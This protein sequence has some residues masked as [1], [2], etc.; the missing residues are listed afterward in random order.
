MMKKAIALLLLT[1]AMLP[2][3]PVANAMEETV[4]ITFWHPHGNAHQEITLGYVED[5]NQSIGKEKGIVV[6]VVAIPGGY[7]NITALTKEAIANG[8]APDIVALGNNRV[9]S[10]IDE[11]VLVDMMPLAERAGFDVSNVLAPFLSV[12]GNTNGTLHSL[13]YS[14]SIPLLYYN[15][16]MAD[17][18]NLTI[19][20]RIG[21]GF[22]TFCEGLHE[23]DPQ[24]GETTVYGLEMINDF[25]YLQAAHIYQLGSQVIA[26][27]GSGSP[28]L[29]D[30]SLLRV[31]E[32]WRKGVDEGWI[33]PFSLENASAEALTLFYSEKL[34][35]V[36]QSSGALARVLNNAKK[37]GFEVGVLPYPTYGEQGAQ[38]GGSNL[39]M[40]KGNGKEEEAFAFV[41]YLLS[42][43]VVVNNAIET[44][45]IPTTRSAGDSSRMIEFWN[46]NTMFSIAYM[47][48]QN[49]RPQENPYFPFIDDFFKVC[50]DTLNEL[51]QTRTIT[52][53]EAVDQIRSNTQPL[54]N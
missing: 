41:Q 8:T 11:D 5:F 51:I 20:N 42:D 47:Q 54:F 50:Q 10:F 49:S 29:E 4:R 31:L 39:C 28:M 44:G 33:R 26:F 43:E 52:P 46:N 16:T 1:I 48:M 7:D 27:D 53:Q 15:K 22:F 12:Y 45:Y 25:S 34:G 23:K 9:G 19:D 17:A 35:A 32:D 37:N 2:T 36:V 24:T 38:I 3:V 18:K 13:P 6:E 21:S 40:I 30:G 14:R